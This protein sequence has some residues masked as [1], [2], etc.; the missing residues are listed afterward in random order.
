MAERVD[1]G[2]PGL[3]RL[4]PRGRRRLVIGGRRPRA[5]AAGIAIVTAFGVTIVAGASRGYPT[6]R[7][8][9]L[10][11]SAWLPSAHV[12]QLTLLDGS[13]A[14]VGAQ[15]Q[16]ASPGTV[17][18][19]VQHGSAAYAVD[20]QA[21]S[22]RRVDGGTFRVGPAATPIPGAGGHLQA[23]AGPDTLYAL[24]TGRGVLATADAVSLA[25]VG[26]PLPLAIGVSPEAVALD[27]AGRLWML[28]ARTGDLKWMHQGQRHSRR[29]A[30]AP[31][32]G[33]LTMAGG[34]PVVIDTKAGT[35]AVLDPRSGETRHTTELDLRP[36]DRIV[37]SG[38]SRAPRLYVVA[39]RGLL[40]ICD[41]TA[42]SC[43]RAVPLAAD[44]SE[45]GPAVEAS[46]R[47]FIPD[48]RTGKVWI[49]ELRSAQ[50]VAQVQV[51]A[52][53]TR[54]QLLNRDGVVFFND[55]GSPHAGVIHLDGGIRKVVKY[56]P[57]NPG[58]GLSGGGTAPTAPPTTP[59]GAPPPVQP[60]KQQDAPPPTRTDRPV[61]PRVN[62]PAATTRPPAAAPMVTTSPPAAAPTAR[63]VA[64]TVAPGVNQDVALSLAT[65]GPASPATAVW[66]FGDGQEDTGLTANH[67]WGEV[68]TYSV[69]VRVTFNDG[70]TADA[71]ESIRVQQ[72]E[73][74]TGSVTVRA[75]EGGTVTSRPPGITCPGT[76]TA[77][78]PSGTAVTLTAVPRATATL[79]GWDGACAGTGS[80]CGVTVAAGQT[81]IVRVAFAVPPPVS[82]AGR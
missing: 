61:V 40:S 62:P 9:L 78:F 79:G 45:P 19:V 41:L 32:A 18:D 77:D 57:T 21:G 36:D 63:I 72:V 65:T 17:V 1:A 56:D 33:L 16:V 24:D 29:Q 13:T 28:D 39:A 34:A 50:V 60:P 76:C 26:G 20:R 53:Q 55:P 59:S 58:E 30:S 80:T 81:Q 75:T 43:S 46:D 73:Q 5:L 23:F 22:I 27:D 2:R 42:T 3:T 64:S 52:P 14:Q 37:V 51:L 35:A 68:R 70:R 10:S 31:G 25:A 66:R 69:S 11:G 4:P 82:L 47:L 15:V 12:G 8:H 7:P 44:N 74:A 6:V 49:I 54:F 48:Y 67:R 71:V 38:S